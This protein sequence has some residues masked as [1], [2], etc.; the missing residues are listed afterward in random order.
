MNK[1]SRFQLYCMLVVLTSPLAFLVVPRLIADSLENN[2]WLA[3]VASLLPGLIFIYIYTSII[4]KSRQ[5]FPVLLE[6]HLG[7][8]AGKAVGGLY[9]LFFLVTTSFSLRIFVDFI[10]SHVLPGTPISVFVGI[11]LISSYAGVRAGLI[12]IARISE[13]IIYIG[14]PFT[15]LMLFLTMAHNPDFK[16]LQPF[17]YMRYDVFAQGVLYGAA[18]LLYMM[19]V[20]TLAYYMDQQKRLRAT[21]SYVAATYVLIMGLTM[22]GTIVVLGGQNVSLFTFPAFV[23]VR[24]INIAEFIQNIDIIFIGVWILG[25]FDVVTI[26][27]FMACYTTQKVFNLHDYRF[28]AAPTSIIIGVISIMLSPNILELHLITQR[29]LPLIYYLFLLLIPLI[30]YLIT[31]FKPP[32]EQQTLVEDSEPGAKA[33]AE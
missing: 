7:L 12:N 23:T 27:W 14:I 3:I 13:I 26:W 30:I 33:A 25:I 1:I 10:E 28:L 9:I 32:V 21:L 6:E 4:E 17:G 22:V 11:M 20:L 19:P 24:L 16:N 5:P 31:L 29:V 18:A 8:W 2:A 15:V